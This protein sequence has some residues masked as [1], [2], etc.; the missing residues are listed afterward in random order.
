[1]FQAASVVITDAISAAS[2]AISGNETVG[3]TLSVTG[4]ITAP[5]MAKWLYLGEI[6]YAQTSG[7]G[8]NLGTVPAGYIVTAAMCEVVSA[9]DAG[10]SNIVELGIASD[11][12]ALMGVSDIDESTAGLQQKAALIDARN[13]ALDIYATYSQAGTAATGGEARFWVLMAKL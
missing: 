1:L 3:G 8:L 7:T 10:D 13:S 12:D 9:F 6:T 5:S 2:A 11:A 4:E